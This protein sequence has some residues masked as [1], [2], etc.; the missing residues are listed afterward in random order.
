V[1]LALLLARL[2]LAALFLVAAVS[3]LLGGFASSRKALTD[4]G[5]PGLLVTPISIALPC[6]EL[7]IA[8]LLL[9]ASSARIGAVSALALLLIFNAAIAANLAVGKT[10]NCNCFG[11]LHSKPISWLTFARNGGLVAL[12]G[13]LVW[14]GKQ[15]PNA[16]LLQVMQNLSGAEL[17]MMAAALLAFAA[18]GML[19]LVVLQ[20]FRQNGRLLLRMEALEGRLAA[21]NL[22]AAAAAPALVPQHGL[23]I[24]SPAPGFDLANLRGGTT[25]LKG[26][27]SEGK[28]LLLIFSSP[29]CGPCNALMPDVAGWQSSLANEVKVVLI[30]DGRHD[31]NRAKAAEHHVIDV[32]IEKKRKVAE[33]YNAFGTPT[34]VAIRKDGV[35]GSYPVGGADAIRQLVIH[36]GWTEAGFAAFLRASAQPQMPA[37]KPALPI[38]SAAPA[39]RL[40]DLQ[41]ETIDLAALVGQATVLLFW[42]AACGFCQRM[43]PQLIEWE[44]AKSASSPRLVLVSS[45][46]QEA[47]A[48][49]GLRSTILRDEK[50]AV[51]M[52]Y[53]AGGTPSAVLVDAD[54]RISSTLVVGGPAVMEMLG[55]RDLELPAAV[56][57]AEV[58]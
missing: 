41:G 36:K 31:L 49:M 9:P 56:A 48:Q 54:G 1:Y 15:T 53:G 5:V 58:S 27:L 8:C 55:G 3:K 40:P 45:S 42:N 22:G 18:I 46:S 4:F 39:F 43:L 37:P 23:P 25:S 38:G 26:L 28:A 14:Q 29:N 33:K 44:K 47:N 51:G 7:L 16:N 13:W 19:A 57:L 11:Q 2:S 20:L 17:V 30:S 50:F 6:A 52:A 35:I 34:A 21:A 12:A 24:G 32:L 10:P